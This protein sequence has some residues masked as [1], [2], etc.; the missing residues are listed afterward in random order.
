MTAI[1][2]RADIPWL[3][4]LCEAVVQEFEAIFHVRSFLPPR[5]NYRTARCSA[6][7]EKAKGAS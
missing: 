2:N 3:C 7:A 6:C 1:P 5:G 4:E